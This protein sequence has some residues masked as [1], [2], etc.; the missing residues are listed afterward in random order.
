[1]AFFKTWAWAACA[2]VGGLACG[3]QPAAAQEAPRYFA[4]VSYAGGPKIDANEFIVEVRD[5]VTAAHLAEI[6]VNNVPSPRIAF[7]GKVAP[8]RTVYNEAWPYH[9]DPAS[10]RVGGDSHVEVCAATPEYIEEHLSEV[11]GAFLPGGD[12][13]PWDMRLSREVLR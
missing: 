13:C 3:P 1:M 10:V 8:G 6:A 2:L 12:W 5:P 4:F 11:G 9:V 7:V